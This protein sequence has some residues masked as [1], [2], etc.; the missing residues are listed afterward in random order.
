MGLLQHQHVSF[1]N[2]ILPYSRED[3]TDLLRRQP[4]RAFGPLID[5]RDKVHVLWLW[6]KQFLH[7]GCCWGVQHRE[8]GHDRILHCGSDYPVAFTPPK[9]RIQGRTGFPQG[10]RVRVPPKFAFP[11]GVVRRGTLPVPVEWGGGHHGGE[12]V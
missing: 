12:A 4:N 9:P 6:R 2:R 7:E 11:D 5:G 8:L 3:P 1:G 10:L